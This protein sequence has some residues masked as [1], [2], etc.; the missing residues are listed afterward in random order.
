MS[1]PTTVIEYVDT[2]IDRALTPLSRTVRA[3]FDRYDRHLEWWFETMDRLEAALWTV[4][5][6]ILAVLAILVTFQVVTR[7]LFNWIPVWGG[8]LASYL[9]IWASLLMLCALVW[10]DTHLQVE[11]VFEKLPLRMRRRIRSLQLI[12]I[13]GFA[14]AYTYYGWQYAYGAGFRSYSTSLHHFFG[15]LPFVPSGWRLDMFWVYIIL[16]IS[17]VLFVLA[18]FS[19]LLQI[20]YYP[21]QLRE[22]YSQRYGAVEVETGAD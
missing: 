18:A 6:T 16:P 14:L 13:G 1:T 3:V 22:D 8:E 21:E 12:L 11:F 15:L 5:K 9:G 2:Y 4:G 19:K 7:Y 10:S 17:G 20:N